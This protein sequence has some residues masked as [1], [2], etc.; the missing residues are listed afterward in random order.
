MDD[1][2]LTR[3]IEMGIMFW[4]TR[5]VSPPPQVAAPTEDDPA[6]KQAAE[7]AAQREKELLKKRRGRSSLINTSG[8]GVTGAAAL[9]TPT[10]KSKLGQ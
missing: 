1:L 10:L 7:E 9:E 3:I 6:T 8:M 2:F 5:S 4:T